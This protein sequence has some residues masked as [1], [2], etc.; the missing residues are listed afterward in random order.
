MSNAN[1]GLYLCRPCKGDGVKAYAV[2][3]VI[4]RDEILAAHFSI[5]VGSGIALCEQHRAAYD[6]ARGVKREDVTTAILS[7][8]DGDNVDAAPALE[9]ALAENTRA[10][11]Q[12]ITDAE[13][14]IM[15][16]YAG[17]KPGDSNDALVIILEA[18][19]Q[20]IAQRATDAGCAVVDLPGDLRSK[21]HADVQH[22]NVM[23]N[24]DDDDD[25]RHGSRV[26]SLDASEAAE[27]SGVARHDV[28]V[29][30]RIMRST[31]A[32]NDANVSWREDVLAVMAPEQAE[33]LRTY[34]NRD[35]ADGRE[36][37]RREAG[38]WSAGVCV[39]VTCTD[40]DV[41]RAALAYVDARSLVDAY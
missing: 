28:H 27:M 23:A 22:V 30:I 16:R 40:A 21:I 9:Q 37:T 29:G 24:R 15:R 36:A 18:F 39:T 11:W 20:R 7:A 41:K 2:K 32:G 25:N 31:L 17:C 34:A 14:G 5:K 12:S 19:A 10:S 35:D 8:H 3:R 1:A 4:V 6:V 38:A 26:H 13:A 33:I